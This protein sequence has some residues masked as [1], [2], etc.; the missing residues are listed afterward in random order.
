MMKTSTQWRAWFHNL[1]TGAHKKK[2]AQFST[3]EATGR[4]DFWSPTSCRRRC[5][6]WP[7]GSCRLP[8]KRWSPRPQLA[9]RC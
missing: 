4:G 3:A 8:S 6:T 7:K 9:L 5:W 2:A 1:A